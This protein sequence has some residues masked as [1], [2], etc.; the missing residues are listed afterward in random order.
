[1]AIKK[2]LIEEEMSVRSGFG[3]PS[4]HQKITKAIAERIFSF[5]T[6][7]PGVTVLSS[8]GFMSSFSTPV[9]PT[10]I[11]ASVIIVYDDNK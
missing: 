2:H 11:M 7:N 4:T 3:D 1:M 10:P 9:G 5:H 6:Q 8:T